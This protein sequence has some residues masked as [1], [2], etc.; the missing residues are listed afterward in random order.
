MALACIVN[1]LTLA[2]GCSVSLGVGNDPSA[3]S[4]S[5]GP[6]AAGWN[7]SASAPLAFPLQGSAMKWSGLTFNTPKGWTA[8]PA[9]DGITLTAPSSDGAC[10][11]AIYAPRP[12][13]S[14]EAAR[15]AQLLQVVST[16]FQG[17][18]VRDAAGNAKPLGKRWRGRTPTFEFVG[19]DLEV[20]GGTFFTRPFLAV[21]GNLAV[22][23]L[24]VA[25]VGG[26]QCLRS[27]QGEENA[28]E[29]FHSLSL[30]AMT[31]T[32]PIARAAVGAYATNDLRVTLGANGHYVRSAAS[33]AAPPT[34]EVESAAASWTGDG[35]YAVSG[36]IISFAPAD[37]NQPATGHY[38][39]LL[40][41][42][43]ATVPG[44]WL[45]RYCELDRSAV[46]PRGPSEVCYAAQ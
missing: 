28:L 38:F 27:Q 36:N 3:T 2:V 14:T 12:A 16:A 39:R 13:A 4:G 25:Q 24:P 17:R 6:A 10:T 21:F 26:V 5:D 37:P 41:E 45:K 44:G 34:S 19:Y 22:P 46:A 9:K 33:A 35:S 20:D 32:L 8:D 7:G 18:T 42:E 40:E 30:D 23:V 15:F 31:S 43:N 29:V 11:M 1:M